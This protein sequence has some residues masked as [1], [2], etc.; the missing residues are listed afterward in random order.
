MEFIGSDLGPPRPATQNLQCKKMPGAVC[1]GERW[2]HNF[3]KKKCGGLDSFLHFFYL[4]SV[5]YKSHTPDLID[6]LLQM[7]TVTVTSI[8]A[9]QLIQRKRLF[10]LTG[11]E[12]S[13]HGQLV[14]LLLA[15][16][17]MGGDRCDKAVDLMTGTQKR[18]REGPLGPF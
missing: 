6:R 9:D 7:H 1:A 5:K 12:V 18:G 14:L 4:F 16:G 11:L 10:W 13:V 15:G 3:Q 2:R 8:W 17:Q